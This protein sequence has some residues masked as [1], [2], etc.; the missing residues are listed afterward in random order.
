MSVLPSFV[1]A[2]T[3]LGQSPP[4][5]GAESVQALRRSHCVRYHGEAEPE[6][7]LALDKLSSQPR[8]LA[9]LATWK[10]VFEQ[11]ESSAMPPATIQR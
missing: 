8:A 11:L 9:E 7:D 4:E 1:I 6:S 5:N 3:T 10:K 2:I